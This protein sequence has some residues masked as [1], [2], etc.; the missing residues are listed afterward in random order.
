LTDKLIEK[1]PSANRQGDGLW[2][3]ELLVAEA[4]LIM[5]LDVYTFMG[6]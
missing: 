6:I 1:Y 5:R 2:G 4:I 3:H